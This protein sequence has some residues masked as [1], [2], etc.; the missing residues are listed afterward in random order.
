MFIGRP[1]KH[2]CLEPLGCRWICASL[3][4]FKS[5]TLLFVSSSSFFSILLVNSFLEKF[6]NVFTRSKQNNGENILQNSESLVVMTHYGNYCEVFLQLTDMNLGILKMSRTLLSPFFHFSSLLW[7]LCSRPIQV[8]YV[9]S[10]GCLCPKPASFEIFG[11]KLICMY[12]CM[13]VCM[14]SRFFEHQLNEICSHLSG[15]ASKG[16]FLTPEKL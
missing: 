2:I 3:G 1:D 10:L 15:K 13:Y 14:S 9:T 6:F 5:Q 4:V 8:A 11:C 16:T 12:V 7:W